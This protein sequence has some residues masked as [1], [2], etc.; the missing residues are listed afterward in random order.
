[1]MSCCNVWIEARVKSVVINYRLWPFHG[2]Q[3]VPMT[4][5]VRGLVGFKGIS[6]HE[7]VMPDRG[8]TFNKGG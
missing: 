3:A 2:R 7:A 1:M 5:A 8:D 4:G 6:D